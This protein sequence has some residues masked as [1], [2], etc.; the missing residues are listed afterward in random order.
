MEVQVEERAVGGGGERHE[1]VGVAFAER[2]V[3][4]E[5]CWEGESTGNGGVDGLLEL[6]TGTGAP[7]R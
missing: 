6:T 7:H 1:V 3:V 5:R 4:D 2:R